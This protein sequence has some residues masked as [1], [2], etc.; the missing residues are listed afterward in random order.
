LNHAQRLPP[1]S[2]RSSLSWHPGSP[3][4][5]QQLSSFQRA[6]AGFNPHT[7]PPFRAPQLP[8]AISLSSTTFNFSSASPKISWLALIAR[9]LRGFEDGV[10]AI[11][12]R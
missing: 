7:G 1:P 3:D 11:E 4:L 12:L 8:Q 9:R 5:S 6:L 10:E 2:I